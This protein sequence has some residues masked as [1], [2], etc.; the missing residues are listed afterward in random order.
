M[1]QRADPSTARIATVGMT[2]AE[3]TLVLPEPD[4][5]TSVTNRRPPRIAATHLRHQRTA[6]EEVADVLLTERRRP[7]YGFPAGRAS[8]WRPSLVARASDRG[9]DPFLEARE[10]G[11]GSRP[12]S[13]A[14]SS[15]ALVVRSASEFRPERYSASIRSSRERSRSGSSRMA[16]SSGGIT[17]SASRPRVDCRQLLDRVEVEVGQPADV[18][19]GELLV[20]EVGQRWSRHRRIAL[21]RAAAP[22]SRS[23][24]RIRAVPSSTS[25][26]NARASIRSASASQLVPGLAGDDQRP[27]AE[28]LERLAQVRDVDLDRMRRRPRRTVAPQQVDQPVDGDDLAEVEHQDGEQ[29]PLLR[30]AQRRATAPAPA[31]IGPR[32]R[33]YMASLVPCVTA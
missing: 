27:A 13:S 31:S 14:S 18:R 8:R 5:P 3:T 1:V 12:S 19:L 28:R 32:I 15:A 23:P 21:R 22:A 2:P 9:Q 16:A 20:R 7:L 24:S 4:G 25:R 11:D 17:S 33:K 30:G 29:R 6:T 26:S 10:G